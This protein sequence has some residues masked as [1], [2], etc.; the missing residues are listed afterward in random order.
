MSKETAKIKKN[1]RKGSKKG[2]AKN[3]INNKK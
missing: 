1:I 3:Y 2:K